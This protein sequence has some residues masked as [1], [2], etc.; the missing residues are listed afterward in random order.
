MIRV[1]ELYVITLYI[2]EGSTPQKICYI[3]NGE[4]IPI[5]AKRRI[6]GI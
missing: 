6:A 1:N 4:G 3:R 5:Q 2:A